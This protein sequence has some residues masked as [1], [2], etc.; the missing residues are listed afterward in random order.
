VR[1]TASLGVTIYP[2]DAEDE[3][4]LRRNADIA[5]YRAKE[6]G[7]DNYQM[8][9]EAMG[10]E[11]SWRLSADS[12]LRTALEQGQ[13]ELY[14]Q[15][16]AKTNSGT[17]VGAEALIRWNHPEHGL[18][19]PGEFISLAEETG[20]IAPLS[21]WVLQTACRQG[22][23]W[24]ESGL[25][26]LRVAVNI[27]AHQFL[28]QDMAAVVTRILKE[29]RF[30]P[31]LLELEI[32]E[33]AALRNA[34]LTQDVLRRLVDMGI[35]ISIDDFGTGYSSLT[36]LKQFPIQAVKIDRSFVRDLVTDQNDAVIATAI[37]N[38]AHI[39]DLN[40]VAEGVETQDQ[41]DFIKDKGCDEFQGYLL[42]K[43]MPASALTT[44]LCKGK[45]IEP[46]T[47]QRNGARPAA[48]GRGR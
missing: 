48:A 26:P 46:A 29:S 34:E 12:S 32:T 25:G 1:C 27:S 14:Y 36:Y 15:P 5:M 31:N 16:I 30:D 11:A 44:M 19:L 17:I 45:P 28:Q 23:K 43:P 42:A 21:E 40:V 39:L 33:S 10:R 13:F 24:M 20:L 3:E 9:A 6:A 18:V 7:R 2:S 35:R 47:K 8:Y 41:L 22:R 37:I 4:T 38:M